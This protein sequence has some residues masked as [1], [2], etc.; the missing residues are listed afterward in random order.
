MKI[1]EPIH[2][3][4]ILI[5]DYVHPLLLGGLTEN[6][7][8]VNYSPDILLSELPEIIS[9]Y[10]GIIINS[11]IKMDKTL[12]DLGDNLKF[13]ARLGSGL[14]I[15]DTEYAKTK[16]IK[17]INSPHGNSN[18]VSEHAMGMLL[19][20]SNNLIVANDE[21]KSFNWHREKNRGWEIEGKTIGVV[22]IGHTGRQFLRKLNG[23][24]ARLLAYDKYDQSYLDHLNNVEPVCLDKLKAESDIISFHLPLT[25]ETKHLVDIQ[26]LNGCK[27]GVVVVNTSRG[28]VVDTAA[29][30]KGLESGMVGGACLD[31]FENEKPE[32]MSLDEKLMYQK[33]F[34]FTNVLVSPHIAGW[35]HESLQKIAQITL[36]K[37]LEL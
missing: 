5:T 15:I 12:I 24:N 26:F 11:K 35:T 36:N 30:I 4:K 32:K 18:A 10:Y 27:K 34:S 28:Q 2:V 13:I 31:V 20:L 23:W 37:I 1:L 9:E 6:N 3:K 16:G 19:S 8:S 7:F 29:L 14:E 17:V 22:G 21:V 25:L 33:L